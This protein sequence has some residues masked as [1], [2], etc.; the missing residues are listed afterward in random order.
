YTI[1]AS[2]AGPS[3]A[4]GTSVS[5][6]FPTALTGATWTCTAAGGAVCPAPSGT[7]AIAALVDLPVG[8]SVTFSA[9][10]TVAADATGSLTNTATAAVGS[11][12][13][14]PAPGNNS[15]TDTDTLNPTGDL[16]IT[17]TD[18]LTDAVPG[19]AITYSIVATNTGPSTVTGASVV[20]TLPVGLVG[21][22][23]SCTADP[24]SAC[25]ASG[26][27]GINASV[28]LAPGDTA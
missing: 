4:P 13:T 9:T 14:D 27:G 28:T 6:S 22:T 12:I 18:G 7:G 15:A 17:K 10:G 2:N 21:A 8:D 24:G 19:S 23:W 26:S 20:D 5:D 1:V 16:V 3:A 11:G 25:P